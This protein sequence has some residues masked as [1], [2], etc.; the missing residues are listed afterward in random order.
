MTP[1]ELVPVMQWIHLFIAAGLPGVFFLIFSRIK[2]PQSLMWRSLLV[3]F[4][5][6]LIRNCYHL[7]WELPVFISYRHGRGDL[8]YDGVGGNV[9][10]LFMGW[11]EPAIICFLI[12]AWLMIAR[13]MKHVSTAPGETGF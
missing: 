7:F 5:V 8:E 1:E 9:A 6:W 4:S 2:K 3:V 13:R 12:C 10:V 11:F